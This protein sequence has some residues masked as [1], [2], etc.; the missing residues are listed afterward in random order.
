[1]RKALSLAISVTAL[2][3][4]A[5][6]LASSALAAG[7]PVNTVKPLVL[8]SPEVGA[9][10]TT[11]KG[12][13]TESPTGYAYQWQRCNSAGGECADIAGAS[14]ST[15]VPVEADHG[16]TLVAKVT[17]SNAAGEAT[18]TSAPT[19]VILPVK[20]PEF[21]LAKGST[22]PVSFTFSTAG[23][24]IA[25][26]GGDVPCS[27]MSGSGTIAGPNQ[28]TGAHMT[29]SGCRTAGFECTTIEST[30]L[31]G[32]FGYLSEAAKTVGLILE[33]E[34]SP[35][36]KF[37]CRG[38]TA[39]V[40]GEVI[41]QVTPVDTMTTKFGLSY[42]WSTPGVQNPS[43]FEVGPTEQLEWLYAG[44]W[45]NWSIQGTNNLVT[46]KQGEIVA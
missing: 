33:Q 34:S 24:E 28:I 22:Y 39:T 17:A 26:G 15:Y 6:V 41:G 35:F 32:H 16:H 44:G 3:A 9:K 27:G 37:K 11:T 12:T 38:S 13:W 45:E 46:A 23:A 18:A 36:A 14:A 21:V 4:L 20:Y 40:Q 8:G 30:T 5:A 43:K 25:W 31:H 2:V 42:N 7:P 1:M 19:K 10:Q 29:I